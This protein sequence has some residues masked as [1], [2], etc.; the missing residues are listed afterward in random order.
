MGDHDEIWDCNIVK[1]RESSQQDGQLSL[2]WGKT[3]KYG[4]AGPATPGD[5]LRN[6]ELSGVLTQ[7]WRK[8]G[9][10]W[11]EK[12]KSEDAGRKGTESEA[13]QLY[14]KEDTANLQVASS[15][16][17]CVSK[18]YF[19]LFPDTLSSLPSA[20]WSCG[21]ATPTYPPS[22]RTALQIGLTASEMPVVVFYAFLYFCSFNF[23]TLISWFICLLLQKIDDRYSLAQPKD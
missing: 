9:A 16:L 21:R 23:L 1:S 8:I 19:R 22:T 12:K 14:Q 7:K 6:T 2:S 10:E 3:Y 15:S 17:P 13:S 18:W 20:T 5:C 4:K 11:K